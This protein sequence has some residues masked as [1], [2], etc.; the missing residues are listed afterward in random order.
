MADTL[1]TPRGGVA[2]IERRIRPPAETQHLRL[3][4]TVWVRTLVTPDGRATDVLVTRGLSRAIDDAVVE[5]VRRTRFAPGLKNGEVVAVQI[6]LPVR[7]R[8][9]GSRMGPP[10]LRRG[11]CTRQDC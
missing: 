11:P 6:L 10:P 4:G 3:E 1:P 7:F 5:A 8:A 2:A 9:G